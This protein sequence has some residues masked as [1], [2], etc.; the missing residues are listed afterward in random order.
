MS[1]PARLTLA[2]MTLAGVLLLAAPAAAR[3]IVTEPVETIGRFSFEGGI[4]AFHREDEFGSPKN[5]YET[6]GI[7]VR[8]VLGVHRAVDLGVTLSHLTQRL[9]S[10]DAQ[11]EGSRPALLSPRIKISPWQSLGFLL[12]YNAALSEESEQELPVA[13]GEDWEANLL[14]KAGRLPATLNVGYVWKGSYRSKFGV[15]NGPQKPVEPGDLFQARGA[16]EIPLPWNF[17]LLGELAYYDVKSK[18]IAGQT[19]AGSAG[20]AADA[21]AGLTWAWGGWNIGAAAGWG[22]LD[23]S[24]TSFDLERGAGDVMYRGAVYYRLQ[25]VARRGR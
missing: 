22:L 23:E 13:R 11:L 1:L 3:P 8:A 10:G 25:P 15:S 20:E 6:I 2:G 9:E 21:F 4:E 14:L 7:P 12:I 18:K 5:T 16:V 17:A 19:L 24:H